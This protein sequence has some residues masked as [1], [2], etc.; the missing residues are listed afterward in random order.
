VAQADL[1]I[2]GIEARVPLADGFVF[3]VEHADETL[4]AVLHVP[5]PRVDVR[6]V[7]RTGGR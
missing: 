4:R 2:L 7:D 6:F 1:E 3:V 5:G